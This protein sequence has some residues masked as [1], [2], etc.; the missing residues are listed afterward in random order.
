[1]GMSVAE[2]IQPDFGRLIH[3]LSTIS[4]GEILF[5]TGRTSSPICSAVHALFTF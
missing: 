5:P 4:G 2:D 1:M 3:A